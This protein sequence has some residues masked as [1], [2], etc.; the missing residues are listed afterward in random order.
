MPKLIKNISAS[1][2]DDMLGDIVLV[3]TVEGQIQGEDYI[4]LGGLVAYL[5]D[6]SRI[7]KTLNLQKPL[8][9]GLKN[10]KNIKILNINIDY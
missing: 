7:E 10:E 4:N 5:Q 6:F 9:F 8:V 3:K 2:A 1:L